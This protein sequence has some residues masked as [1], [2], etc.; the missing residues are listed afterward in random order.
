MIHRASGP[1]ALGVCAGLVVGAGAHASGPN[2]PISPLN[3]ALTLQQNRL[4]AEA[5]A[6]QLRWDQIRPL[7]GVDMQLVGSAGVPRYFS[8]FNRNSA[9]T[10]GM[11]ELLPGGSTGLD[12][13]G[14]GV[15]LRIWDGGR[16]RLTHQE[17]GSRAVQIDS[18]GSLSGHATH[19]TGT[20]IASGVDIF[21]KGMAPAATI[22]CFDFNDDALEMLGEASTGALLSNHSYG[23][24]MGWSLVLYDWG[25]GL[26]PV[27]TWLWYGDGFFSTVEDIGFGF[28]DYTAQTIDLI[29][30]NYPQYLPVFAASNDRDDTG[31]AP[32]GKHLWYN[33]ASGY[34]LEA[35]FD[36]RNSDGPWDCLPMGGQTAKNTLVVGSVLDII[37]GYTTPASVVL[38][39]FSST[40]PCDDS[41]IKPDIVA[42]GNSL[43]SCNSTSNTA[44]ANSSGTSMA[45]PSTPA[46]LASLRQ[47]CRELNPC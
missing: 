12:L 16:V 43:Y 5:R 6:A 19:V 37:G 18:P 29:T 31:P 3:A 40:G 2:V 14:A 36:V 15:E 23:Y 4:E 41:R 20:M 47:H 27:T 33:P 35:S 22:R 26:G 39:D 42:N 13:T 30:E 24:V 45:A 28:Y 25:D 17:F 34:A 21:A 32:G 46:V 8:T 11:D 9:D 38:N 10:S 7:D 44:Y 1:V